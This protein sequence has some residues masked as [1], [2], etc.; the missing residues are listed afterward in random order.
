MEADIAGTGQTRVAEAMLRRSRE[1][2]TAA[3]PPAVRCRVEQPEPAVV[4][5]E[6]SSS[7]SGNA[8]ASDPV[9]RRNLKRSAEADPVDEAAAKRTLS[10]LACTYSALG[11]G[12]VSPTS[13]KEFQDMPCGTVVEV[14]DG[15]DFSVPSDRQSMM[16]KLFRREARSTDRLSAYT[17]R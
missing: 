17:F 13:I 6:S 15:W 8:P 11:K 16:D 3:E 7:A 4:E 1:D 2:Q 9:E 14:R 12:M 5:P 10:A